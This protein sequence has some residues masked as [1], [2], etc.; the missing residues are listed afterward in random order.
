MWKNRGCSAKK[1]YLSDIEVH[2]EQN[3]PEALYFDPH[4]P[5]ALAAL[6]RE[7][8]AALP[9]GPDLQR[10]AQTFVEQ[11]GLVQE[12]ARQFLR[13]AERG[14]NSFTPPPTLL[15]AVRQRLKRS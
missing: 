13:I 11:M 8:W 14:V 2:R 12:Y 4:Q 10:E 1:A 6:L 5:E 15:Q 7:T 9:P 3:L